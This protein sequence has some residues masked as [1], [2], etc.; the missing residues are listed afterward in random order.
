[1]G[2][3]ICSGVV[4]LIVGLAAALWYLPASGRKLRDNIMRV[5]RRTTRSL[6]TQVEAAVPADPVAES[7]AQGKAAARR[8]RDEL[9]LG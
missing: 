2:S 1:M 3:F 4:G 7:I 9:G 6:Q 8:R 5:V